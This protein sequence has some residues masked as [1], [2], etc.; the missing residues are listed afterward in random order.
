[1]NKFHFPPELRTAS[2]VPRWS[3][4]FTLTS[5]YVT[6][7]S[8][9]VTMYAH[10]I[11]RLIKWRGP[12]ASL[13]YLALTHGLDETVTGDIV[14][15]V[16]SEIIDKE[17][18][19]DYIDLKMRER[20]P[21]V[22]DEL[23]AIEDTLP[24]QQYNEAWAIITAADRLDALLFLLTE[25]RLGNGVI[26]PRVPSAQARLAAV[27]RELPAPKDELDRLWATVVVP[28]VNAHKND[29]GHGI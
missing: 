11:A 23:E 27:W 4:V 15:I 6:N 22:I 10:A 13:M 8:Y 24:E 28:S 16:K 26:A 17:R 21:G 9:F 5:D 12:L 18:A 19:A 20:L 25:Q 3:I 7:H 1:M 14:S 2:I 29:G